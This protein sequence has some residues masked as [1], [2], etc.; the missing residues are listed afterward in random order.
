MSDSNWVGGASA[1]TNVLS[2]RFVQ[3]SGK[4]K[5]MFRV[6][7]EDVT[8]A[9]DFK[10]LSPKYYRILLQV[11]GEAEVKLWR[12]TEGKE[13][14]L[15]QLKGGDVSELRC[16]TRTTVFPTYGPLKILTCTYNSTI[17]KAKSAP[18]TKI[19]TQGLFIPEGTIRLLIQKTET[20]TIHGRYEAKMNGMITEI[21]G[22]ATIYGR[23]LNNELRMGFEIEKNEVKQKC[24]N[25]TCGKV[26]E[27]KGTFK[28]CS[29]C[30]LA[31][32]CS[33][34]C[35]VADWKGKTLQA[36]LTC[37]VSHKETCQNKDV[38][39]KTVTDDDI[40]RYKEGGLSAIK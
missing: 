10:V 5:L 6:A 21:V 1:N 36:T 37:I 8:R 34:E 29:A 24:R 2:Q 18:H 13:G 31:Y 32:Y 30:K 35:Q 19:P 23:G 38:I 33:R 22:P 15:L 25:D 4:Q 40:K 14:L 7:V 17:C 39:F 27:T 9:S 20:I 11:M 12:P 3:K 28:V 26:E 16:D